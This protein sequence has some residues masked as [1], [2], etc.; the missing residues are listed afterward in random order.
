MVRVIVLT[1]QLRW[2]EDSA[3]LAGA[4]EEITDGHFFRS[5][6]EERP[7][8]A[9]SVWNASVSRDEAALIVSSAVAA[10]RQPDEPCHSSWTRTFAV[11]LR[12]RCGPGSVPLDEADFHTSSAGTEYNRATGLGAVAT[13]LRR[14]GPPP[15]ASTK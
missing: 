15:P 14:F 2:T 10:A 3:E 6:G 11:K 1:M 9:V 8:G 7:P 5:I 12:W 13:E 4:D